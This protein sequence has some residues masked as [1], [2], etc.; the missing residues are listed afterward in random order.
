MNSYRPLDEKSL[1]NFFCDNKLNYKNKTFVLAVSTGIDSSVLMDLFL[2]ANA[3]YN[4]EFNIII[5]HVNHHKREQSDEEEEY[6][7]TIC[8]NLNIKLYVKD[9][10][11]E[12]VSNFQKNARDL[13]YEFFDEV[14]S[15]ENGDYLVLAHHGD[16]NVETVLMRIMRGSSLAGYSGISAVSTRKSYKIIRPLL[17]YSK[18][19]IINYQNLH[20]IK[21]YED[22]SN[23][24]NDYTRNR[25]RHEIVPIIKKESFDIISK[26]NEF[27]KVLKCA[28]NV[29]N[30]VRDEFID[31]NVKKNNSQ[32]IINKS[33]YLEL[34]DY[35]KEEVLFELVKKDSLSK[36]NIEELIKIIKSNKSNYIIYFKNIFDFMIEYDKIVIDYNHE[37][38]I[39]KDL[40]IVINNIGTYEINDKLT[41]IVSEKCNNSLTNKEEIWYNSNDFPIIVRS[42][43]PG[44]KIDLGF[45]VKKVKD[46]LINKKI[47]LKKR[48]NILILDKANNVDKDVLAILNICKSNK[49][50]NIKNTN[51]VIKLLEK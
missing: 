38:D 51:I 31:R 8:K 32:I 33:K 29:I 46:I 2:K 4:C 13:R 9:L 40:E 15:K 25:I 37:E 27:S 12:D 44:D 34:D 22:C 18:D 23:S 36:A 20:K 47:P 10:Y 42:R 5:C 50:K 3:N 41:L 17:D 24:Q 30:I 39:D 19:D 45:G 11:F 48:N 43:K 6:I 16:D 1:I 7:K 28:S 14:L 21:Y 26:I 49:L 35:L